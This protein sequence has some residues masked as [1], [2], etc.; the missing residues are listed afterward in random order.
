METKFTYEIVTKLEELSETITLQKLT[1]GDE[2]VTPIPQLIASS[3]NGGVVI[4]ARENETNRIVGF[5]YGFPGVDDISRKPFLCSH[6]MAIHPDYRN[7]GLGRKLKFKQRQWAMDFGYEKIT[8]TFDPL[9]VRNG[10]L[11]LCKLG[12]YVRTYIPSY[13][14][15]MEDKL[16]KGIPS[17]RFLLEW[18]LNSTTVENTSRGKPKSRNDWKS[19]L[20]LLEWSIEEEYPV[21]GKE[22]DLENQQGYLL[23]VPREIQK[24][25]QAKLNLVNEWRMKTRKVVQNAFSN[26]YRIV[27]VVR[28]EDPVNYYVFEKEKEKDRIQ[29]I[30]H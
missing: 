5:C 11:N 26:G 19:Y 27:G 17:D 6:M 12:G 10:Y 8:W 25:K 13:Y 29:N 28:S 21:P 1:W 16:N 23:A 30:S 9:E 14:G 7:Q 18:D 2:A 20:Q 3:H 4:A 22:Y 24:I 15:L